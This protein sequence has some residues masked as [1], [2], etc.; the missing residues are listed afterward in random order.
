MP[1]LKLTLTCLTHTAWSLCPLVKTRLSVGQSLSDS[2]H[3][4]RLTVSP[5]KWQPVQKQLLQNFRLSQVLTHFCSA[6][7][8]ETM[9]DG[10][11]LPPAFPNGHGSLFNTYGVVE[12]KLQIKLIW[13]LSDDYSS[14]INWLVWKFSRVSHWK[15]N[16]A[17]PWLTPAS[18]GVAGSEVTQT[19][20]VGSFDT[21]PVTPVSVLNE[22]K[23]Y[24][25][26]TRFSWRKRPSTVTCSGT[27]RSHAHLLGNGFLGDKT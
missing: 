16:Y 25:P 22:R 11:R 4:A 18:V 23:I 2:R 9:A 27:L 21:H 14:E 17:D 3:L 24:T 20:K 19:D 6:W 1:G 7:T 12:R 15:Q 8:T 10:G 5:V 26:A 13:Q